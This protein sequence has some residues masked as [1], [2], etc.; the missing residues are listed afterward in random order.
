LD[1][2]HNIFSRAQDCLD[3]P[4]PAIPASIRLTAIL[5]SQ[6]YRSIV[7]CDGIPCNL[8]YIATQDG[9]IPEPEPAISIFKQ[10]VVLP[11]YGR[12]EAAACSS[13]AQAQT[14]PWAIVRSIHL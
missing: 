14:S 12:C 5:S 9:M 1:V 2:S 7:E 13:A 4:F 10:E 8:Q 3:F 11:F 6:K